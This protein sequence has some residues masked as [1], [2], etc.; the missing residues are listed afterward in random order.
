MDEKE[1]KA[2][3]L[4]R[5][6]IADETNIA[7]RTADYTRYQQLDFVVGIEVHLSGNHTGIDRLHPVPDIC[8]DLAGKYPKDFKFTGWHPLCGCYVTS[9]LKTEEEIREDNSRI[10]DGQEPIPAEESRNFVRDV[11]EGFKRWIEDNE[12]Q[13]IAAKKEG[14]L[15]NFIKD[16]EKYIKGILKGY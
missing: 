1:R 2:R 16:N 3:K 6:A 14:T 4:K 11:P 15:P 12:E 5:L 8:D 13:I 10:L 9:I 7:Y